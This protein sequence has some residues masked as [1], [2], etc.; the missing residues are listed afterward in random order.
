MKRLKE[1]KAVC[2]RNGLARGNIVEK[3]AKETG[4]Y[5]KGDSEIGTKT[6][7]SRTNGLRCSVALWDVTT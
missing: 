1:G 2:R 3:K 7:L 5:V 4:V 6:Q